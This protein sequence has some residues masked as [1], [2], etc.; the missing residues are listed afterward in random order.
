MIQDVGD[1]SKIVEV[2]VGAQARFL[3]S[4]IV[5]VPEAPIYITGHEEV[6]VAVVVEEPGA[7]APSASGNSSALRDVGERAVPIVVAERVAAVAGLSRRCPQ[8]HHY[9]SR[10][11]LRPHRVVVLRH[12]SEAGFFRHIRECAVGVL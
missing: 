5:V 1:A 8:D 4:A 6:E 9:R 3:C 11:P 12:P 7:R 10:P 2:T